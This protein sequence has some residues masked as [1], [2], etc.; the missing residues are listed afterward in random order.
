LNNQ[1]WNNGGFQVYVLGDGNGTDNSLNGQGDYNWRNP[2][3]FGWNQSLFL[4][5]RAESANFAGGTVNGQVMLLTV[6]VPEPSTLVL[7]AIGVAAAVVSRRRGS[8]R[9]SR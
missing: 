1:T 8:R 4:S 7:V 9:L 2:A 6:A 3:M 5:T